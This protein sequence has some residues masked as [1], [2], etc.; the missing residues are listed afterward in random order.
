ML[1][2][3]C[4]L[5]LSIKE[6]ESASFITIIVC[7]VGIL[8]SVLETGLSRKYSQINVQNFNSL[9][10]QSRPGVKIVTTD[11]DI[12]CLSMMRFFQTI[13]SIFISFCSEGI[14]HFLILALPNY[15]GQAALNCAQNC[16][17]LC[18]VL[19]ARLTAIFA[20]LNL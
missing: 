4:S 3:S 11:I 7:L 8:L 12:V 18:V 9:Q 1:S 19:M 10:K 16:L 5:S 17:V 13:F 2:V 20:S 6:S 15:H 14:T